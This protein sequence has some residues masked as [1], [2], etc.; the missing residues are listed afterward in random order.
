MTGDGVKTL[1]LQAVASGVTS[2]LSTFTY[3]LDTTA[4]AVPTVVGM[5]L[6]SDTGV[7]G[8]GI[9]SAATPTIAGKGVAGSTIKLT[10]DS[11]V[12][13]GTATVDASGNWS[14][15]LAS[16]LGNG[17]H[18]ITAT[19]ADRVGNVSASSAAYDL[20]VQTTA[21][22]AA[23]SV[24]LQAASDTGAAGDDITSDTTPTFSITGISSTATSVEISVDGG[25]WTAVTVASNATSATFTP[26]ALAGTAI[27]VTYDVQVRQTVDGV[28]GLASADLAVVIDTGVRLANIQNAVALPIG[29][30]LQTEG[31]SLSGGFTVE[32][33]VKLDRVSGTQ[34]IFTLVDEANSANVIRFIAN[35][36][37]PRVDETLSGN[38]SKGNLST[39]A[40][41]SAAVGE[42]AQISWRITDTGVVNFFMNGVSSGG[43][44]LPG[45]QANMPNATWTL[46]VGA[47]KT[48]NGTLRADVRDVQVWD[49]VRSDQEIA[50]TANLP[51]DVRNTVLTGT[52]PG[53]VL[54]QPLN[55]VT[56]AT[57]LVNLVPGA[58]AGTLQNGATT[59]NAA[60][61]SNNGP[62]VTLTGIADAG[63]TIE[64]L[65]GSTSLGTVTVDTSGEW[66]LALSAQSTGLHTYTVKGTDVTGNTAT[67]TQ[68]V[69]VLA[70]NANV[71]ITGLTTATDSGT[72]GD[73]VTSAA[74]PALQGTA[75]ANGV[76]TIKD[77]GVTI[78]AV[79]AAAS[80]A[81][82]YN[83]TGLSEGAHTITAV[84]TV[85]AVVNTSLSFV[86]TRDSTAP[87]FSQFV[88]FSPSSAAPTFTG[89]TE[90]G[91]TVVISIGGAT[92]VTT[93]ANGIGAFSATLTS[94]QFAA[95]AA[96][97]NVVTVAATDAAGN[98]ASTTVNWM[99]D[100][101]TS[102]A[103]TAPT[104]SQASSLTLAGTAKAGASVTVTDAMGIHLGTVSSGLDGSWSL[105]LSNLRTGTLSVK[106]T[107]PAG[108]TAT[109]TAA[110]TVDAALLSAPLLSDASNSGALGDSITNVVKPT[111]VVSGATVGNKVEIV[112][113][114]GTVLGSALVND[115]GVALVTL[116]APLSQA[117]H[118][119]KAQ[120]VSASGAVIKT[121]ASTTDVTID[122]TPLAVPVITAVQGHADG[123]ANNAKPTLQ[124]TAAA[125][126]TVLLYLDGASNGIAVTASAGGAWTWTPSAPLTD[127]THSVL[128]RTMDVAGNL[129]DTGALFQFETDTVAA[130]PSVAVL[131]AS[132]DTASPLLQGTAEAGATVTVSK[133]S[134]VLGT[135]TADGLGNWRYLVTG[136]ANGVSTLLVKQTDTAG[137]VSQDSALDVVVNSANAAT[138]TAFDGT[139][140][141]A[142]ATSSDTG[143]S[144]TDA[145]TNQSRPTL[146]GSGAQSGAVIKIYQGT[147]LLGQATASAAGT[148]TFTP[149]NGLA[150]GLLTLTAQQV[151]S[152]GTLGLGSS[153]VFT[154][155]TFVTTGV[156]TLAG[157]TVAEDITYVTTATPAV[158]GQGQEPGA[159]VKLLNA[160]G[161]EIGS[162]VVG[163]SGAW[164]VSPTAALSQ[165]A[166]S[167]NVQ[168][169]DVAG[170]VSAKSPTLS[171][172]ID[173]Q[174]STPDAPSLALGYDSGVSASDGIT[175]QASVILRGTGGE[176]GAA[177]S[178]FRD[179]V[180]LGQAVVG[181]DGNW[182]LAVTLVA[183]SNVLYA[184]QTDIAGNTSALSAALAVELDTSVVA[185]A[186]PVIA[187][188]SDTG[189]S[190]DGNTTNALAA[191]AGTGAEAN[192]KVEVYANGTY[193]GAALAD[194]SGAWSYTPT[195]NWGVGVV[196]I[197]T[198]QVDVAGNRAASSPALGLNIVRTP[199]TLEAPTLIAADLVATGIA[200][201]QTSAN[202]RPSLTGEGATPGA[203]STVFNGTT[204][205]GVTSVGTNGVWTYQLP[206]QAS[207][208][209]LNLSVTQMSNGEVSAASSVLALSVNTAAV[210]DVT[211]TLASASDS[212]VD[213]DRITNDST[214]TLSGT[215]GSAAGVSLS[216]LDGTTVVGT[217]TTGASGVWTHTLAAA[218][219]DGTHSLTV[220][221]AGGSASTPLLIVVDT[222]IAALSGAQLSSASD[223]GRSDSDG[224]TNLRSV[225]LNGTGAEAGAVIEVMEAGQVVGLSV[226]AADGT[227]SVVAQNLTDG[228]HA[229]GVRQ[230]DT[231]GNVSTP[232]PANALSVTVK[233]SAQAPSIT[234]ITASTD[235]GV[236]GDNV[237]NLLAPIVSG[238]AA[239][240]GATVRLFE[241]ERVLGEATAASSGA[242]RITLASQDA[243]VHNIVARQVDVAGNVSADSAA[244]S[245]T[246]DTTALAPTQG[247]LETEANDT[248][249]FGDNRTQNTS[250][251]FTGRAEAGATVTVWRTDQGENTVLATAVAN[252]AGVWQAQ[253]T[254]AL[255]PGNYA[256]ATSQVDTAG[257]TSSLSAPV[258]LVIQLD[259]DLNLSGLLAGTG[260]GAVRLM[261]VNGD[262]LI[263]VVAGRLYLQTPDGEFVATGPTYSE[264]RVAAGGQ[265]SVTGDWG[266]Y[267]DIDG[268]SNLD[269]FTFLKNILVDDGVGVPLQASGAVF[270]NTA[271]GGV[272]N[273]VGI[274]E[275]TTY[276]VNG[277][278]F[279][280]VAKL[281]AVQLVGSFHN[282]RS[283]LAVD[284]NQ[285]GY[286]DVPY[287]TRNDGALLG[288]GDG[289]YTA[290]AL[291]GYNSYISTGIAFDANGDGLID[292]Y[293]GGDLL[294]N[295]GGG[296]FTDEINF[297]G[298]PQNPGEPYVIQAVVADFN[299]DGQEDILAG[300]RAQPL[301]LNLNSGGT[302]VNAATSL[303][304]EQTGISILDIDSVA[305][306]SGDINGDR[307]IDLLYQ[308]EGAVL[309]V[310]E[311]ITVVAEDTYL[312]VVVGNDVGNVLAMAGAAVSFV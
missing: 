224:T 68:A 95:A 245:L 4:P 239:E 225:V 146:N 39:S 113:A 89:V 280:E 171:F 154:V 298:L 85:S 49:S 159:T 141:I 73:G 30:Y 79:T 130:P 84:V 295:A 311:N 156:P 262:G 66:Q 268:D 83:L 289:T 100:T 231:A 60:P 15:T 62:D 269:Y 132:S 92:L 223:S 119:L 104:G 195:S 241:G 152:D 155:D 281:K 153:V 42:W 61:I 287:A 285:D 277:L 70:Q 41:Y 210:A 272:Y 297:S 160:S 200:L 47:D 206:T 248:G 157:T 283:S 211:L 217:A 175:N 109:A 230:T 121:S 179:S 249:I 302:F 212:G 234:G 143:L 90:P 247:L 50:A 299:A 128:A 209:T 286:L 264:A 31:L 294:I 180:S 267:I 173:T 168:V 214:P 258:A 246:V 207:G 88:G 197:S 271:S 203:T 105:L 53:L 28:P 56:G 309:S 116:V 38:T 140:T 57:V 255:L 251:I 133:G 199:S 204:Q 118:T 25:A 101:T 91:A 135:V 259:V 275:Q 216:I 254:D 122:V 103:V 228:A 87:T 7:V 5:T 293:N 263:D 191:I 219:T 18:S 196:N 218:L 32:A 178:V 43:F 86:V 72:A 115:A 226:A 67:T 1:S 3:T 51:P 26:S 14:Y 215:V 136:Q 24:A 78:G 17:V 12:Q 236:V 164:S 229:L 151:K 312:R 266:Q 69:T 9:T 270:N 45:F 172:T 237:T 117:T 213:T 110:I 10:V 301:S 184:Q 65:E 222:T 174:V 296:T 81:W 167:L 138:A 303:V 169:T 54:Y 205:L 22:S 300:Y 308:A 201:G 23:P 125:G 170:N 52:E 208:T 19:A 232:T 120:E 161:V 107:D 202:T 273:L 44:T 2:A 82:T 233:T 20:T 6:A 305:V 306:T 304:F 102:V 182:A 134:T 94:A 193:R 131:A 98:N 129:S 27:G 33:W 76:V 34:N 243:G 192:A 256:V 276:L 274:G 166:H 71:A 220:V 74:I 108:N 198:V 99:K 46:K 291:P 150:S 35:G 8:D 244:Y 221:P 48:G 252:A 97:T 278:G 290:I 114:A 127:A 188:A 165:G 145:I 186:Q 64:V 250:P 185:L 238:V 123:I 13:A 55:E 36:S 93:T 112:N 177:L 139:M 59:G 227:Y 162:V 257:N 124:G 265:A 190:G 176:P 260:S 181:A 126:S 11:V 235:S 284:L 183:G 194:A 253:V 240:A 77:G 282:N 40:N 75:A 149:A 37:T 96:G 63:D 163:A 147:S 261:D 307:S 29:G 189:V 158:T 21:P 292:L 148:W 288:N 144:S 137:N 80:G 279:L 58:K 111:L 187:T 310:K 242:W 106:A 16:A 142:L